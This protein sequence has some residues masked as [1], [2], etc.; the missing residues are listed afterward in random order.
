MVLLLSWQS[1]AMIVPPLRLGEEYQWIGWLQFILA[2]LLLFP[3]TIPIGGIGIVFIWIL[4]NFLFHPFHMLDYLMFAGCGIYLTLTYIANAKYKDIGLV[5]LY[6]TV[7][8][9]LC[10]VALEKFIYPNWSLFLVEEHPNLAMGLNP[11]LFIK[12]VAFIE[13]ALGYL[14]LICLLQRPLALIITAIFFLTTLIFGKIE[15]IGHTM[16]HGALMVFLLEGAGSIYKRFRQKFGNVYKRMSFT[17]INF[18]LLFGVLLFTYNLLAGNKYQ[19]KQEFLSKKPEHLHGEIELAGYPKSELPNVWMEIIED[20]MG[21]YNIKLNTINFTFTPEKVNAEHVLG[22][23][24]AHL[25]INGQKVARVYSDW[26]YMPALEP[27][28]YEISVTLNSNDH[29]EYCIRGTPIQA[30]EM[31]TVTENNTD[32]E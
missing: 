32:K 30:N 12:A 9:S 16:I 10:W 2:F 3:K 20:P 28:N 18:I 26:Y 6:I 15:V 21:G 7:G 25:Y 13:F 4:G 5:I 27:G 23:G 11:D 22:E 8:F 1:D 29:N 24:H 17:A 31:L 19:K 14:L